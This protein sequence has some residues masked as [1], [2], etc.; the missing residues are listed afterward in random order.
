[1]ISCPE[2]KLMTYSVCKRLWEGPGLSFN[3]KV[4]CVFPAVLGPERH[5]G[6]VCVNC[7][8][9]LLLF[10]CISN[11]LNSLISCHH[12]LVFDWI[13]TFGSRSQSWD[14]KT[15]KTPG[16]DTDLL[17]L[18]F[19]PF[20]STSLN[21]GFLRP[22]ALLPNHDLSPLSHHLLQ[23]GWLCASLGELFNP[24]SSS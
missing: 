19:F 11:H 13:V 17:S 18:L 7:C 22:R 16:E 14:E 3:L 6:G 15:Q 10:A 8:S 9:E 4:I 2:H 20:G 1:M 12:A 21:R 5:L 23:P 24:P